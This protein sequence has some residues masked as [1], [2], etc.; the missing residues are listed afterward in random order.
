MEGS[1]ADLTLQ[2]TDRIR[3]ARNRSGFL[4]SRAKRSLDILGALSI[5]VV[6][7]PVIVT[8]IAVLAAQKGTVFFAHERVGR[9]GEMFRCYK[10]RTMIPNADI[11]LS[12]LLEND[13]QAR[14][15]WL[16]DFKLRDDPR[17]TRMGRFL[18]KTSLDELPQLWNVLSGSMSLV[19]PR[20]VVRDELLRYGRGARFYLAGKPGLTGLWQVSGRNDLSYSRR[21]A[22]DRTYIEKASIWTDLKILAS[23][24]WVVLNIRGAY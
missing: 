4:D 2:A 12:E 14:A 10:F 13:S 7:S 6:F 3:A 18:R 16:Q 19:G 1:G 22:L 17:V 24:A 21:I 9:K 23:T 15:E 5:G 11:V 8:A 20:P